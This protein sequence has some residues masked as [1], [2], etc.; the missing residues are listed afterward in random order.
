MG[1]CRTTHTGN[2]LAHFV[3]IRFGHVKKHALTRAL[4]YG[5]L[6][7][8]LRHYNDLND[9]PWSKLVEENG[10]ITGILGL[11]YHYLLGGYQYL[12]V[13]LADIVKQEV[14]THVKLPNTDGG[15]NG[16][17]MI[18]STL[19]WV[20]CGGQPVCLG[21]GSRGV[22]MGGLGETS[23]PGLSLFSLDLP[24]PPICSIIRCRRWSTLYSDT[25]LWEQD[26]Q[27]SLRF[28]S[29]SEI[30]HISRRRQAGSI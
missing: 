9:P 26:W 17:T 4:D 13:A 1:F 23:F 16:N 2:C 6:L 12:F 14:L 21:C 8:W 3:S 11:S 27:G 22:M 10:K 29:F 28:H 19:L 30:S 15:K 5:K 25:H 7:H 18:S 20:L 24:C